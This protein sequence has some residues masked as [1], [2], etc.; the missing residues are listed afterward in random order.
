MAAELQPDLL[1]CGSCLIG[2]S[3]DGERVIVDFFA[4]HG[5]VELA[6][7]LRRID[8]RQSGNQ[9]RRPGHGQLPAAARPEQELDDPLDV[10]QRQR[11]VRFRIGQHYG[12]KP[13]DASVGALDAEREVPLPGIGGREFRIFPVPQ[14]RRD[15]FRI[16]LR[17]ALHCNLNRHDCSLPCCRITGRVPTPAHSRTPSCSNRSGSAAKRPPHRESQPRSDASG[18]HCR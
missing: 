16:E 5:V 14:S 10:T 6:R 13:R 9:F 15:E 3:R 7:A 8:L 1:C 17:N 12:V 4:D 18:A 11:A 2:A